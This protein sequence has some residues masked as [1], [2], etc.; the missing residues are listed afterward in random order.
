MAGEF[1]EVAGF[2]KRSEP[3]DDCA[4][5][6]CTMN[7]GPRVDLKV[8]EG[9]MKPKVVIPFKMVEMTINGT[10]EEYG[11]DCFY[12]VSA[13]HTMDDMQYIMFWGPERSGYFFSLSQAGLYT[14]KEIEAHEDYYHNECDTFPIPVSLAAE[15]MIMAEK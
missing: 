5:G 7:C 12:L 14:R 11:L 10:P 2:G 13:K 6:Y 15:M 8:I 3:C 9:D 1:L 4:N